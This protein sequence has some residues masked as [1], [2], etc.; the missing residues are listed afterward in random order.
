MFWKGLSGY[1]PA[2]LAQAFVGVLSIVVFTRLLSPI[3]YGAYALGFSAMALAQTALFTWSEAAMARF[4][5][6]E[7][8]GEAAAHHFRTLYLAWGAV[9]LVFPLL[10]AAVLLFFPLHGASFGA[11]VAGLCM[12]PLRSLTKLVQERRRAA[13][14]VR[15]A[16]GLDLVQSLGGF[17]LGALLIA[18]HLGGAAPLLGAGLICLPC[19]ALALPAELRAGRGGRLQ[20]D[21]LRLYAGY[22]GPVALSLILSLVLAST[23]RFV[24]AGLTGEAAVGAYHAGYSLANR[25]LD[26]MFIWLGSASGPA[27]VMAL[28]RGGR[29]ALAHAAREQAGLMLLLAIPAAFGLALTAEPLAQLMVGEALRDQAAKVTPFIAIAAVFGGFTTYYLHQAFTLGKR[30]WRL[31]LAMAVPAGANLVLNLALVPRYGAQGAA[32]ATAL[33]FILGAASSFTLGRGAMPLPLPWK[34]L[35]QAVGASL[36][37]SAAVLVLPSP[38]GVLELLLKA[39]VGAAV[40]GLLILAMD[41]GGLRSKLAPRLAPLRARFAP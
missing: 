7:G 21:R 37:M 27:L 32:A 11:I 41:A 39:V 38:G 6:A 31:M 10:A 24:L 28:E 29:Q 5:A 23:D 17:A 15:A 2:N 9:A 30:T 36:A 22:G 4:H 13:G 19:L 25:T 16:A 20:L 40:Y 35:A 34:T 18:G 12:V 3:E 1:L 26:V 33:S 8:Q 14:E